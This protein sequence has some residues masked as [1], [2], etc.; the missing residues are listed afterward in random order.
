MY[1]SNE[2]PGPRFH[3]M[4]RRERARLRR[5]E[6]RGDPHAT[7]HRVALESLGCD[8]LGTE[9]ALRNIT[10]AR[11]SEFYARGG[12][13]ERFTHEVPSGQLVERHRRFRGPLQNRVHGYL[14]VPTRQALIDGS[15]KV[16]GES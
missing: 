14:S 11:V 5:L 9:G 4:Q 10:F 13:T 7:A 15:Q 6:N 1:Y 3:E 12:Y 2:T 16:N 8:E